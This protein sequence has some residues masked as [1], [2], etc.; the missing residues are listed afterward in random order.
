MTS[1]ENDVHDG[2]IHYCL[3]LQ[4]YTAHTPETIKKASIEAM[5]II[6]SV[7]IY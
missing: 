1:D 4:Q 7:P 3:A 2:C 5:M 6:A